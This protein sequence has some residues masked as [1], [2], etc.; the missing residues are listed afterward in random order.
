M[1]AAQLTH[2][3]TKLSDH[4]I[5][6]SSNAANK[7]NI[8]EFFKSLKFSSHFFKILGS[9]TFLNLTKASVCQVLCEF[10]Q[11]IGGDIQKYLEVSD[12]DIASGK[13]EARYQ[14]CSGAK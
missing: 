9:I 6:Q 3:L 10:C 8:P 11:Q 14:A 12:E 2:L 13:Q 1:L 7:T 5:K 4:T